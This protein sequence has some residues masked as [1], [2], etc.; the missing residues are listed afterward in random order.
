MCQTSWSISLWAKG[1]IFVAVALCLC[2]CGFQLRGQDLVNSGYTYAV[3]GTDK[4]SQFA[5][6]LQRRLE[7][8]NVLAGNVGSA[9]ITVELLRVRRQQVDGAVNAEAMLLEQAVRLEI[10]YRVLDASAVELM[11]VQQLSRQRY[12]RL[13]RSNVLGTATMKEEIA[14]AL[15]DE[16]AAQLLR[17]LNLIQQN[18]TSA[19]GN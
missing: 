11:P 13:D 8:M 12:F 16:L 6:A 2:A 17:S 7:A 3:T 14:D 10:D 1:L 4:D 5:A 15:E 9:D 18:L 19:N